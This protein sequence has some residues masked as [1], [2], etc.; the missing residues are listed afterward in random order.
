[1]LWS[2][3]CPDWERRIVARESLVPCAPLFPDEARAAVEVFKSLR[4]VDVAGKPTFGD[5]AEP[6]MLDFVAAIFG[7]YD[8]ANARRLIREFL[9]LISKKNAKST[10]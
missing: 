1:M 9:L 10:L 8:S 7:A 3:A 5:C 6:W 2:T 4:L